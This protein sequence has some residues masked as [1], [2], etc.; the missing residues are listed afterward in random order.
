[1]EMARKNIAFT[2]FDAV[3]GYQGTPMLAEDYNY[4]KRLWLTSGKAPSRGEVG[5]Y[6]SHYA[7]WLKCIELGEP[8]I[9]C[10]DDIELHDNANSIADYALEA[11][12]E[13]GFV[14]LQAPC[15]GGELIKVAQE[16]DFTMSLM[17]DNFGGLCAYA[18]SPQ[19]AARLVKHRWCLP[20]DCFVGAN[21]LHGQ[22]SYQLEPCFMAT[23]VGEQS[24]IQHEAT[25][26]TP[27][28]RKPTRELYTLY[29][30]CMLSLMYWKKRRDL[31]LTK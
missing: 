21:Y 27:L 18:M 3:D 22:Y 5:C 15:D 16:G 19:A 2:F 28:H 25:K 11:A 24:T 23:H 31:A 10:E 26:K 7:L 4:R 30:K 17:K 12:K 6:A 8:I 14:R 29:K 13:Y 20:V 9:I 1:M